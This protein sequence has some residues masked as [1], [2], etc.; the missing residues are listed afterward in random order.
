MS[1]ISTTCF[2]LSLIGCISAQFMQQAQWELARKSRSKRISCTV[3]GSISLSSTVIHWYRQK[4]GEALQRI[5]HFAAGAST[6]TPETEFSRRFSGGKKDKTLS[7]TITG[8]IE[9]DAA[10]YYCALYRGENEKVFSSGTRL[11]VADKV[12]VSPKVSAYPVS[13]PQGENRVLLCEARGMFPDMVKFNWKMEDQSGKKVDLNDNE[14]LEQRDEGQ[15][16]K[17]TSML[18]VNK[19]KAKTNKFTC[20]VQHGSKEQSVDIPRSQ[21]QDDEKPA[22][23][24]PCPTP[25]AKEQKQAE[26]EEEVEE[27]EKPT[28]GV[29][30]LKH[31]LNLF[32]VTYVILLLKNVLYFC[33]VS[34]LLYKRNAANKK[35]LRSKAR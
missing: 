11:Y 26:K 3:D 4:P 20:S 23:V 17:L 28:Y 5:L 8:V 27:M 32:S 7:L 21:Q 34:V 15:E 18:I 16:V 33:T 2:L 35:M 29:T 25:K 1:N 13:R 9:E 22:T 24:K 30:E 6:A 10:N 19:E 12:Y 14:K 31:S